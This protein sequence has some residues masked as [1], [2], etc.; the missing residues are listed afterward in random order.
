MATGMS[1][2]G[3]CQGLRSITLGF[4][5]SCESGQ[6]GSLLY[7]NLS[8]QILVAY[9]NESLLIA[10]STSRPQPH[11]KGLSQW[12]SMSPHAHGLRMNVNNDMLSLSSVEP[13]LQ[14]K[15][16]PRTTCMTGKQLSVDKGKSLC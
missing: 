4:S 13:L 6:F 1:E 10:R 14:P 5:L 15:G 8:K 2:R 9:G 7:I 3:S 11:I 16:K 12:P